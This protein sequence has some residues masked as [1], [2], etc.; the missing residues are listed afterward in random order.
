ME[1]RRSLETNFLTCRICNKPF[2]TPKVLACMHTFCKPCLEHILEQETL[3]AAKKRRELE[4]LTRSSGYSS[5]SSVSQYKGRWTRAFKTS[6]HSYSQSR[7]SDDTIQC[8]VC[9]KKTTLP[10]SGV[11]GLPDDQ[12]AGKLACIVGKI[13]NYPVC[14][15]CSSGNPT[16]Y[17]DIN[18]NEDVNSYSKSPNT[19]PWTDVEDGDSTSDTQS[20]DEDEDH[21]RNGTRVH[22]GSLGSRPRNGRRFRRNVQKK[23]N[24]NASDDE[25]FA[26]SPN[27]RKLAKIDP[28]NR[29]A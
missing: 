13:P 17:P 23:A 2:T 24:I 20:S 12:M 16:I 29:H 10:S 11:H 18:I 25:L 9:M 1:I 28:G 4:Q 21:S 22:H 7:F 26:F 27:T 15:V 14:D 19:R 5:S 6:D 3:E 8:P